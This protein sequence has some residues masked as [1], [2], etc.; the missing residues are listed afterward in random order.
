M[1]R[2]SL[3]FINPLL[4][5]HYQQKNLGNQTLLFSTF[6]IF[7]FFFLCFLAVI[8]MVKNQTNYD[9]ITIFS[10]SAMFLFILYRIRF[11]YARL[12]KIG[13]QIFFLGF[14]LVLTEMALLIRIS[15][16]WQLS[17]AS[18]AFIIPIQSFCSLMLLVRMNWM[19]STVIYLINLMY[20]ML[21][22][23][24]IQYYGSHFYVFVGL[25]MGVLNFSYMAYREQKIYRELF[26]STHDSYETLNWYHLL[27]RNVLPSSIFILNYDNETPN[28]EFINFQ[29]LKLMNKTLGENLVFNNSKCID[30]SLNFPDHAKK[31]GLPGEVEVDYNKINEFLAKMSVMDQHF[32]SYQNNIPLILNDH[33]HSKQM[34]SIHFKTEE[35]SKEIQFMSINLTKTVASS[36][37]SSC[38]GGKSRKHTDFFN[39]A[40]LLLTNENEREEPLKNCETETKI[41]YY[42][43][44]GAKIRWNQK[45][46]L[47]M[48]LS[49]ITKSKKIIELKTLD[50]HKNELLASVSH[51]LR[52]PLNGVIGMIN[53]T[54]GEVKDDKLKDFL[55]V[56]LRS[57]NLLDFLIKDILD[58][59]QMSYKQLRLNIEEFE[60]KGVIQEMFSL[61]KFQARARPIN[62]E[63]DLDIP[64]RFSCKSDPNRLKQILINLIGN[65]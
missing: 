52:T 15:D 53:A 49:D 50:K 38:R 51:D 4:E 6:L 34:E 60:I 8:T 12:F 33:F 63:L 31:S 36:A 59:S 41:K 18:V 35:S 20:F 45:D 14:G 23:V 37:Y 25:F 13:L 65:L 11:K 28:I 2:F 42:E 40:N 19:L 62:L 48:L 22:L 39:S 44:K 10:L 5:A 27:M 29:A 9:H 21:R 43:L 26:K 32:E 24:Q 58:F 7:Q 61:M 57:A 30:C 64:E 55:K 54:M 3:K 16:S 17:P 47:L 1:H 46:C 56:A